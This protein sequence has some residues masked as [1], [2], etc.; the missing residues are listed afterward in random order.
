LANKEHNF[1]SVTGRRDLLV[2]IRQGSYYPLYKTV[3]G[4]GLDN[5]SLT[6]D[7][8]SQ[9]VTD[10]Y[11]NVAFAIAAYEASSDVNQ[12]SSKYDDVMARRATFNA[13]EAEGYRLM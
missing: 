3:Y 2:M 6:T 1:N 5:I 12:F 10:H 13:E 4:A 11:N 7:P 8:A 9:L